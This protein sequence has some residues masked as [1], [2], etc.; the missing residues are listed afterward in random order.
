MAIPKKGARKISVAGKE[1]LW[2]IRRKATYSQTCFG[3]GYLHVAIQKVD[4]PKTIVIHTDRQH[5]KDYE[6]KTVRPIKPA[7]VE[8]WILEALDLG[9]KPECAGGQINIDIVNERLNFR[10]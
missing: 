9:W 3:I 7:D 1:Y 4:C 8:R 6:T 5:P 10:M 2:L